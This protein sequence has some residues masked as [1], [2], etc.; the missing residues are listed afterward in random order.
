MNDEN[1]IIE[2]PGYPKPYSNNLSC[3][4]KIIVPLGRQIVLTVKKFE[5]ERS[6]NCQSDALYIYD[7]PNDKADLYS[8]PYCG[9]NSP[10]DIKSKSNNLFLRFETDEMDNA[11]G[12]S[13]QYHSVKS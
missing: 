10:T 11:K 2:S 13:M 4:W 1:G 9:T 6:Y 12:F 7:G 3:S 5:I 8:K